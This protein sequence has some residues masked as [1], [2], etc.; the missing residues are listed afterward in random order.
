MNQLPRKIAFV[1][2]SDLDYE[3][4]LLAISELSPP[5]EVCRASTLQAARAML[6]NQT[7]DLL[8][9]D[10]NITDGSGIHLVR[11]LPAAAEKPARQIVVF[12]TSTNPADRQRALDAGADAFYEKPANSQRFLQT[13]Q[14]I[15][16]SW[17]KSSATRHN[18]SAP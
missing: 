17:G 9:V 11:Q 2:D 12:S 10:I 18:S 8:I 14:E 1:E 7:F 15:V 6:E 4:S 3:M 13:V 16:T 5:P